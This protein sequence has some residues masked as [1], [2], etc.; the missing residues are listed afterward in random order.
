MENF[1]FLCSELLTIPIEP[2]KDTCEGIHL[3]YIHLNCVIY[4]SYGN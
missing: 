4:L 3:N 2:S 1:I